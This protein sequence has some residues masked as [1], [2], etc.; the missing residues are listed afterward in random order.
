MFWFLLYTFSLSGLIADKSS[1]SA[2]NHFSYFVFK[3]GVEWFQ[4]L[5]NYFSYFVMQSIPAFIG[6][7]RRDL[8]VRPAAFFFIKCN[9]DSKEVQQFYS[10]ALDGY[11]STQLYSVSMVNL[12]LIFS[13]VMVGSVWTYMLVPSNLKNYYFNC[14][15][16]IEVIILSPI[17]TTAYLLRPNH[18]SLI[19]YFQIE[20]EDMA[21]RMPGCHRGGFALYKLMVDTRKITWWKFEM[22]SIF[23][24]CVILSESLS[25]LIN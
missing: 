14:C 16:N 13:Q 4:R 5:S 3:L 7:S 25:S 12:W 17:F 1:V 19:L 2:A 10:S 9:L 11:E 6:I 21:S 22:L 24:H 8:N 18:C 23:K 15:S 20:L